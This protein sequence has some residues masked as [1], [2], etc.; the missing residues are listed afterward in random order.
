MKQFFKDIRTGIYNFWFFRKVIWD[1]RWWDYTFNLEL[2]SKSLKLTS[3]MIQEKGTHEDST[4]KVFE[5]N[6]VI[7]LID[8]VQSADFIE[9]A[10]R[11]I[12]HEI[13]TDRKFE[14]IPGKN[15]YR[16]IKSRN[17]NAVLER[18]VFELSDKLEKE[19]W[20]L[21]WKKLNNEMQNWW[22]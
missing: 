14:K 20:E 16:M 12:G 4:K 6:R 18:K 21:I 11:E 7:E 8:K 13:D 9:Q 5:I 22:D 3:K 1:F 2:F 10:E 17:H 15:S 19:N